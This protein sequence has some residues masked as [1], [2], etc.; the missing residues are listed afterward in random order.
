[1]E[2]LQP[3]IHSKGGR[4]VGANFYILGTPSQGVA[5]KLGQG[6]RSVCDSAKL[7][8]G[9]ALPTSVTLT[10]IRQPEG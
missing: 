7:D 10:L 4:G 6:H 1:M 9:R 3:W 8:E 2:L 5:L